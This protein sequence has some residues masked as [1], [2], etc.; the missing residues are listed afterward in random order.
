MKLVGVVKVEEVVGGSIGCDGKVPE[1]YKA[2]SKM[3][4][5]TFDQAPT[6]LI[7]LEATTYPDAASNHLTTSI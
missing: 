6:S 4:P 1:M 7:A 5:A 3:T 2:A